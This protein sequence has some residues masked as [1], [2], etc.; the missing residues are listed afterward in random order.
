MITL[1]GS[2]GEG[3]GQILRTA[4]SLSAI[5]QQAF[6]IEHIRAK[7]KKPGL[8]RQHLTAVLAAAR[9]SNAQVLGA[10]LGSGELEFVPQQIQPG[11]YEFAIGSAGSTGL[12]LQTLLPILMRAPAPST[13]VL[14]GGTHNPL[15][16]PFDFLQRAFLPLLARMGV[17][18]QVNL[19]RPGFFP[20]GG[21]RMEIAIAP[22]QSLQRLQLLTRGKAR[23]ISAHAYIAAIPLHVAERELAVV[24]KK[25]QPRDADLHVRG[26]GNDYGPGNM[27][28]VTV[29][30]EQLT[31]VFCGFGAHGV[32]AEA[33]AADVC[34]QAQRYLSG[35]AAVDEYLA[36]QLLLPFAMAG[37]GAFT[38]TTLSAHTETNLQVIQRFLDLPI[39]VQAIDDGYRIGVGADA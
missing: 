18:V 10:E 24:K 22:A 30:S 3:G 33:V 38:T 37:A 25:L 14:E 6:R 26:L 32:S 21:G 13:L 20:A 4:L 28:A 1:D 11:H 12:V 29:E 31:E 36:D 17:A 19:I 9:V 16:P 23:R 35:T 5:T 27:L 34:R 39:T 7:R 8:L 15:A 2:Q